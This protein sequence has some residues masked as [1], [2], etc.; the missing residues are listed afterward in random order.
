MSHVFSELTTLGV[1]ENYK[2]K[3]DFVATQK[4]CYQD[5][6]EYKKPR[7][8]LQTQYNTKIFPSQ[9]MDSDFKQLWE[10]GLQQCSK[11]L[12]NV[13]IEQDKVGLV[14]TKQQ[15][16]TLETQL[17]GLESGEELLNKKKNKN[18]EI[19]QKC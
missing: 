7:G 2:I 13:L 10:Q 1:N 18:K 8:I 6:V 9:K 12:I 16:K 5:L 4:K 3:H 15:I 11:I 17:N 19:L 14:R